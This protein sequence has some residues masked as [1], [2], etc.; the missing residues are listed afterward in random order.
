MQAG[1]ESSNLP[2]KSLQARKKPPQ[3]VS[4]V[5]AEILSQYLS[6]YKKCNQNF[7]HVPILP[8]S[9]SKFPMNRISDRKQVCQEQLVCDKYLKTISFLF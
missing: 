5:S 7:D 9:N 6:K 4:I 8:I 2:K 3:E 1:N